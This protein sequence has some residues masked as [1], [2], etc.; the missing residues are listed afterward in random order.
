MTFLFSPQKVAE[1]KRW[2]ASPT[3]AGPGRIDLVVRRETG[4]PQA[5]PL[6][7]S[8]TIGRGP[9]NQLVIPSRGVSWHHAVIQR[10]GN[11]VWIRDLGSRNGSRL[12]GQR[13]NG[14]VPWSAGSV[15]KIG[16]V[17]FSLAHGDLPT[18]AGGPTAMVEDVSSGLRYPLRGPTF[19]IG[20]DADA[21]LVL[22]GTERVV[23]VEH[24]DGDLW[25]GNGEEVRP[26]AEGDTFSVSGVAL[27]V[28]R[29]DDGWLQ[30]KADVDA[31]VAPGYSFEAAMDSESGPWARFT[32]PMTGLAHRVSAPNRVAL[33]WF[34][35][36]AMQADHEVAPD[37]AGWRSNN[38]VSVAV[39]GKARQ[40]HDPRLL[41]ALIHNV[42]SELRGAGLDPWCLEKR[43]GSLR[44]RV[45]AVRLL[46]GS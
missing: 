24:A 8:M 34:L 44:L 23:L 33:L 21:D 7:G 20:S 5:L 41:K 14:T 37:D 22:P 43:R 39:W 18:R 31:D 17:E 15:L 46:Q 25:V 32:D 35:A 13:V 11:Q 2:V 9:G 10:D 27:R 12:D 45:G 19:V 29:A 28:V 42:R 16:D 26:L 30:T 36:E 38:A 6:V 40:G 3:S 4:T 1:T